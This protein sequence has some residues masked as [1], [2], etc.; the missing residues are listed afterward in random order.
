MACCYFYLEFGKPPVLM[1]SC[2]VWGCVVTAAAATC[3]RWTELSSL[4]RSP[5]LLPFGLYPGLTAGA[6]GASE[7]QAHAS[8]MLKLGDIVVLGS[9]R[10]IRGEIRCVARQTSAQGASRVGLEKVQTFKH[11]YKAA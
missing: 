2:A 1:S 8:H 11:H 7:Q 6:A 4:L 9:S 5:G 10:S 3:R